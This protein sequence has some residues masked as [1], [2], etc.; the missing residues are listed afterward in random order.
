M[1]QKSV[2][3]TGYDADLI[4]TVNMFE[5]VTHARVKEAFYFK[6][7]LTFVVVEGD[8]YK[9]L[10][11]GLVNVKKLENLLQKKVKII[12]FH[13]DVLKFVANLIHP[14]KVE[15][16]TQDGKIITITD[17]DMKTKGLIIGAKAQNLRGY[18]SVVKK[19]FDIEE[20]KVV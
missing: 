17:S 6:E 3:R 20:L 12:E 9:A 1:D 16:I 19:Y 5:Q 18:E 14:Y 11:K 7:I 10:G 13:P 4:K 8:I 2:L 15:S